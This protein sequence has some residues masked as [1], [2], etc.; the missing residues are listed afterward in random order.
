MITIEDVDGILEIKLLDEIV[1]SK[2]ESIREKTDPL[3]FSHHSHYLINLEGVSF[4]DSSGLGYLVI[5]I[6]RIKSAHG[7]VVLSAP[8]PLVLK[9]LRMIKIDKYVSIFGSRE[10]ALSKLRTTV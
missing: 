6:K 2:L 9:F 3:D 1:A 4:F 10:E 8:T 7:T 5:L